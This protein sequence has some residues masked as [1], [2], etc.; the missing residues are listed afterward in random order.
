MLKEKS[1]LVVLLLFK[2]LLLIKNTIVSINNPMH[3][4]FF[5]TAFCCIY[6]IFEM[7]P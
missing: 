2:M 6:S 1:F 4:L 5:R 3:R 7:L